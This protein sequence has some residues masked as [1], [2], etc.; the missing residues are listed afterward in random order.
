MNGIG[1]ALD[2][3]ARIAYKQGQ[4][5]DLAWNRG[6]QLLVTVNY[7]M[8][9]NAYRRNEALRAHIRR[10]AQLR[11]QSLEEWKFELAFAVPGTDVN[12]IR[13]SPRS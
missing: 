1:L 6:H 2:S 5:L 9:P 3:E 7:R 13:F 10:N 12:F 4:L 8:A 11:G